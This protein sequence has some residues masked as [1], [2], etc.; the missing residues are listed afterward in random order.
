MLFDSAHFDVLQHLVFREFLKMFV[1]NIYFGPRTLN[2][3]AREVR[4]RV[5]FASDAK[6][7]QYRLGR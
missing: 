3:R 6:K 7:W 5:A 4:A 2:H 1:A